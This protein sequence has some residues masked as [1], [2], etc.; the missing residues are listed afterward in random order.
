M[1]KFGIERHARWLRL[2]I[3]AVIGLLAALYLLARFGIGL[4]G[5]TVVSRSAAGGTAP[6][7]LG[8]VTLLLLVASMW[9]LQRML[10]KIEAGDAFSV[11]M[12]RDFR[13]FAAWLL[14]LSLFRTVAP[15]L[16]A[17]LAAPAVDDV[18]VALTVDVRD[19]LL[20]MFT[21]ILF[22]VARLLERARLAEEAMAEI[23]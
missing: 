10:R 17:V 5:V 19:L 12:V 23:V 7:W 16:F 1:R 22:L 8:D 20:L 2:A 11:A 14:A 13:A 21:L 4:S 15:G 3:P 18:R 6:V 9:P